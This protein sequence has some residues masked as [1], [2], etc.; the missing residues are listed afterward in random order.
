MRVLVACEESQKVTIELRKL[1]VEAFSCDLLPCSGGHPEW[2]LQQDV[3]PL[4]NEEWDMIIAFPP[5]TFMT[6]AGARWMYKNGRLQPD[7]LEE[8]LKAKEFFMKFYNNKCKHICIENPTPLKIINLP[9]ANQVIQP[10]FFGEPYSKRTNLW[11]KGLPELK[12]T[13]ILNEFVAWIPSNTGC[14]KN[15]RKIQ[16]GIAKK[17]RVKRSKTFDGIAKA[18]ATQF[19][20]YLERK[21][22]EC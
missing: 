7:R 4:L 11:L 1:G 18:M 15:G 19:F 9:K 14:K 17:N 21:E 12:P 16:E 13:H 5:C 3:I 2:H 10:Y 6:K 8:A 22:S 20:E